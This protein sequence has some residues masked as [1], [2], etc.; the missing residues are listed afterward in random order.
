M[1]VSETMVWGREIFVDSFFPQ[2]SQGDKRS[3]CFMTII[4]VKLHINN[5]L[6]L[7]I[8]DHRCS[9]VILHSKATLAL[10]NWPYKQGWSIFRTSTDLQC[11]LAGSDYAYSE[12]WFQEISILTI[13]RDPESGKNSPV[14]LQEASNFKQ[15]NVLSWKMLLMEGACAIYYFP[16]EE[17]DLY[18]GAVLNEEW[19]FLLSWMDI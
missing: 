9:Q 17:K 10:V 14:F 7:E 16:I 3:R 8:T 13:P 11:F 15:S 18:L 12:L 2:V 4:G 1:C 5:T 6:I 19:R